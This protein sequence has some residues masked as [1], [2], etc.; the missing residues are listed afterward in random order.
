MEPPARGPVRSVRDPGSA[1]RRSRRGFGGDAGTRYRAH[2]Q[3]ALRR[4]QPRRRDGIDTG[5]AAQ[6][7][8]ENLGEGAADPILGG[9]GPQVLESNDGQTGPWG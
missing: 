8:A 3:T 9:V 5:R 2:T 4:A 7:L 1:D 6:F